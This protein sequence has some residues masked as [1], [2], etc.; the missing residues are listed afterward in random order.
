MA[1]LLIPGAAAAAPPGFPFG[2]IVGS[3]HADTLVG[4]GGPESI[5]GLGGDD[6]LYGRG[7]ADRIFGGLGDDWIDGG[8]GPDLLRGGPGSD[9]INGGPGNDLILAFGDGA[10]DVVDCG[11]GQDVAVVDATD[12][13]A[14][15]C[16][17]VW[18]RDPDSTTGSNPPAFLPDVIVGTPRA[19]ALVGTWRSEIIFAL[20]GDDQVSGRAGADRIFGGAGDDVLDGGPG[21]DTIFGGPGADQITGGP[22]NDLIMAYGDGTADNISCGDGRQDLAIVDPNDEVANDCEFVW[23]RNPDN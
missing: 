23:Q 14:N 11:D 4:T 7:G 18:V 17:F 3:G 1:T 8:A 20:A 16:E 5:F 12:Q 19:D 9:H 6:H 2:V 13:V 21:P 15:D 22:G 10:A